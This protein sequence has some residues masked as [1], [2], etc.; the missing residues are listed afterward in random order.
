M[1]KRKTA[2]RSRCPECGGRENQKR[3]GSG[4]YWCCS[5]YVLSC[6]G[7]CV[8]LVAR[9]ED[10]P[11]YLVG[12]ATLRAD[13]GTTVGTTGCD[14][15]FLL[16]VTAGTCSNGLLFLSTFGIHS[17]EKYYDA[18]TGEFV[19]LVQISDVPIPPCGGI[20]YIPRRITCSDPTVTEVINMCDY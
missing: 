16:E 9:V 3:F 20:S 17:E 2:K 11:D 7:C 12:L 4:Y 18:Q 1:A 14:N 10:E 8:P 15:V 6:A 19:G 13:V 5:F